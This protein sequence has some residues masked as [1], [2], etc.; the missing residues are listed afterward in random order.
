MPPAVVWFRRDLRLMDNP[1]LLDGL[2]AGD[3]AAVALFVLD[4]KLWDKAGPVRRA[5]LLGSLRSLDTALGGHLVIRHG[6]PAVVVPEVAQHTSATSVHVAADF[7]PLG[8]AR[9]DTV[10]QHLADRSIALVR[11]GSSYAV[12]PGRVTKSDGTPYRVYTPFQRAWLTHGWRA[13]APAPATDCEWVVVD[14]DQLPVSPDLGGLHLPEVGEAAALDRWE[15]FVS[16]GAL[17]RYSDGRNR[18]DLMGTSG[19]SAA[20]RWGEIHP[21]T[22]LGELGDSKGHEVFRKELAWR[23]FYADVLHHHPNSAR[24]SL[25]P[26]LADI[27][28]DVGPDADTRFAA[29]AAGRTGYPFVDAGMRQLLA[30]GWMHNRLRM[31][32][33]SFLVKDLHLDWTRGARHFMYWLRDGDLASNQHGW[34]WAAGTGTDAAPYFRVFNPVAQGLRFDPQG[35]YVRKYVPELGDVPGGGVHEPWLRKEGMPRDYPERIVDHA[36]EREEA[37][38]RYSAVRASIGPLT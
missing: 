15:A 35:D 36:V 3:G 13:P 28:V 23:E 11:T 38:A 30:E 12:A 37:L 27:E 21:R 6:D 17:D 19:L 29:W 34:Q 31:V 1:A 9:D 33:A 7:A 24:H 2:A 5:Y 25:R 14:G 32:T 4:P 22:L 18:P 16:S 10:E 8:A 26:E 20:L